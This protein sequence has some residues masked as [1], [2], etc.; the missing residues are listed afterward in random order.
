MGGRRDAWVTHGWREVA[1]VARGG[2]EVACRWREVGR[3]ALAIRAHGWQC[4]IVGRAVTKA[5]T[6]ERPSRRR[7]GRNA[8]EVSRVCAAR[9]VCARRAG[10]SCA[11]AGT[12]GRAV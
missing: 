5:V 4:A 6:I 2:R 7:D 9:R 10:A 11:R 3:H 12:G 8:R 1:S